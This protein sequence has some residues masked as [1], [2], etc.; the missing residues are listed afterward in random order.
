MNSN[1]YVAEIQATCIPN[2]QLVTGGVNVA[3][4]KTRYLHSSLCPPA[5]YTEC[6]THSVSTILLYYNINLRSTRYSIEVHNSCRRPAIQLPNPNLDLWPLTLFS[7]GRGIVMDYPFARFSDFIVLA[8]LVLLCG[9]NHTHTHTHRRMIAILT[10]LSSA[11]V[12]TVPLL[13]DCFC[14][15]FLC[16]PCYL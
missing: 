9:Q 15:I 4:V 12:I 13:F 8:V 11:W 7:G 3:L 5:C 16:I 1:Y 2:E 10:P 14:I 6:C